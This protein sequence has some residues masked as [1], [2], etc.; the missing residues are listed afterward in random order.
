[1]SEAENRFMDRPYLRFAF[2]VVAV[3]AA[4][5]LRLALVRLIGE[6]LPLFTIFFPA[7]LASALYGGLWPALLATAVSALV[8]RLLDSDSAQKLCHRETGT[9]RRPGFLCRHGRPAEPVG[10][11]RSPQ[12]AKG[13]SAEEPTG[14]AG[15]RTEAAADGRKV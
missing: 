15:E 13:G 12:P 10:R 14:S 5:L 11:G 7:I 2:A 4:F 3:A 1:M 9:G 6:E 8:G